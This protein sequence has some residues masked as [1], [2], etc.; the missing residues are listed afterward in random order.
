MS[1]YQKYGVREVINACGKMTILGVST[2]SPDVMAAMTQAGQGFVVMKELL[3]TAGKRIA[4]C[5]GAEAGCITH[6][7]AAGISLSIAAVISDGDYLAMKSLPFFSGPKKEILVQKGHVINFGASVAQMIHLGGGLVKEFGEANHVTARDLESNLSPNTAG[8]LFVQSHHTV[9]KGELSLKKTIAIAKHAQIPII[10]DAAAEESLTKFIAAGADLVIY[11]GGKSIE[12]PTSGFI[13]GKKNWIDA[14]TLQY[15]GIGR[16]MKVSKES[17]I[18]LL[19]ALNQYQTNPPQ[20][21]LAQQESRLKLIN[22][23]LASIPGLKTKLIR[24]EAGR[25]IVRLELSFHPSTLTISVPELANRLEAGSPAIYLRK[26]QQQNH[27]LHIDP[28]TF[29]E[30]Q[31]PGFIKTLT[32]TLTEVSHE[33]E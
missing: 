2:P 22:T 10:V 13:A 20:I 25:E 14:C 3:E 6:G 33:L 24:D 21:P 9:H 4:E 28:R 26:Y 11:S 12:G 7:A 8:I 18:G 27:R 1:I 17:T 30:A 29:R 23:A 5:T 32:K 31:I 19:A 15:E 16:A